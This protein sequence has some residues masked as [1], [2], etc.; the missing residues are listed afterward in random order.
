MIDKTIYSQIGFLLGFM[1]IR[2]INTAKYINA[3][4]I[5]HFM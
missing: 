2:K 3:V 4:F 1:I 5:D